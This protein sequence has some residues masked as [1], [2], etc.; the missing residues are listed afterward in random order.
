MKRLA[1]GIII[2]LTVYVAISAADKNGKVAV[3]D[4]ERI[5]VT[6]TH[7]RTVRNELSKAID[8]AKR[9]IEKHVRDITALKSK[10]EDATLSESRRRALKLDLEVLQNDLS[11]VLKQQ[12]NLL[13][14]KEEEIT[15]SILRDVQEATSLVAHEKDISLVIEKREST[16]IFALDD[17]DITEDVIKQMKKINRERDKN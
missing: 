4:L 17:F 12:E 6:F 5:F 7:E 11:R 1:L 15:Q 14:Q 2:F 16:I 3:I 8:S 10:I 13:L 9:E